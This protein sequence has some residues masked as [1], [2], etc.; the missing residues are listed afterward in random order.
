M[1]TVKWLPAVALLLPACTGVA[2]TLSPIEDQVVAVGG[3][4]RIDLT[5]TTDDGRALEFNY[6][7]NM[8]N[9]GKRAELAQR[10]DG[11]GLFVLRPQGTEVGTWAFDFTAS[12]G[13][14][15]DTL[16]VQIEVKSAI[17]EL[18]LPLFRNPL[19]PGTTLDLRTEDCVDLSI[20][21]DD[22]DSTE[23]TIQEEEPRIE[24]AQLQRTDKKTARW[25]WCPTDSQKAADDRYLLRLSADDGENPKRTINYAIVLRKDPDASCPGSAPQINHMPHDDD[26]LVA[27]EILTDVKDDIG[28]KSAPLVFYGT[29][30]PGSSPNI[31]Q[32]TQEGKLTMAETVMLA[33]NG[34]QGT[35]KAQLPNPVADKPVGSEAKLYYVIMAM[36]KDDPSGNCDHSAQSKVYEITVSNPGGQGL[37]GVCEACTHDVQCGGVNDHCVRIGEAGDGY[38][39]KGCG[40]GGASCPSG[41]TCSDEEVTSVS[42]ATARQCVPVAG[43]CQSALTSCQDDANEPNDTRAEAM[44]RAAVATTGSLDLVS[45]PSYG[46]FSDEDWFK[47]DV[48]EEN[49]KLTLSLVGSRASDLDL[50]LFKSDG[51]F[52]AASR[53]PES[54]EGIVKSLAK[55]SYLV[56][57]KARPII[58]ESLVERNPYELTIGK[59]KA[60]AD[61]TFEDDDTIADARPQPALWGFAQRGKICSGDD[62]VFEVQLVEGETLGIELLF[63]QTKPT[64]NL[65]LHFLTED[66]VDLW[67]CS[68]SMPESCSSFT[69]QSADSDESAEFTVED[70]MCDGGLCTFYVV[71]RGFSGS[72]NSY[73]LIFSQL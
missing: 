1:R 61:D 55:G 62:D 38:C 5:A 51:T 10:P 57:A 8:P 53:G 16:T 72:E 69:G 48:T 17:G 71:V 58:G 33:G 31:T 46:T 24:R 27:V 7:T 66:G 45:C 19:G 20:M 56:R 15:S 9:A 26:T 65:D 14:L 21:V 35:Y 49:T 13:S 28:L 4:L 2:P 36:D 60:C 3:E 37:L 44:A 68:E 52:L 39:A 11:T 73:D 12:D 40:E 63:D 29:E 6:K 34:K 67:P 50:D 23:V 54:E 25:K 42:G 22:A 70:G 32:L 41:F 43:S 18:T 64:E 47:V 59:G 30:N